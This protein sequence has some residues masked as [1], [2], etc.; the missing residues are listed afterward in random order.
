MNGSGDD[1][2][3]K[4]KHPNVVT[5][6][7]DKVAVRAAIYFSDSSSEERNR[8]VGVIPQEDRK[9]LTLTL[10]SP[11]FEGRWHFKVDGAILSEVP[12]DQFGSNTIILRWEN[13]QQWLADEGLLSR[14]LE[15]Q[16]DEKGIVLKGA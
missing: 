6:Y 5:A 15:L 8:I 12:A 11:L 13:E 2:P 14:C 3:K 10:N 7:A 1:K 9:T 4:T 16:D